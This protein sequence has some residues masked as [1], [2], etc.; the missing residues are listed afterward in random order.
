TR[1]GI[2]AALAYLRMASDPGALARSDVLDTVRRPSRKIARNVVEML[3]KRPATS[4]HD[5]RRLA[6]RLSGR[7]AERLE[8]YAADLEWVAD[9]LRT[10]GTAAAL[11]TVRTG[12][13]LG[14]AMDVLDGS[15]READRSTHADDLAALEAVAGL[16]REAATFEPWLREVLGRPGDPKG[17]QLSTIHRVKGRQWPYVVVY[18]VNDGLLPH[19]LASDEAE[20]RRIFHVGIT[21]ASA[22]V[23]V[24]SDPE[25]PSPF[26]DELTGS[27]ERRPIRARVTRPAAP[28]A[29]AAPAVDADPD[30]REALRAWRKEVA[31]RDGVPAYVVL[32]DNDLDGIAAA[33]PRSL[34]ELARCRGIGPAKLDRYGDELLAVIDTAAVKR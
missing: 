33:L 7:D 13:G 29:A 28:A 12:I 14:Q 17:V 19:R 6:S 15:R 21:R 20:E 30:V 11:R 2:R 4:V 23:V 3:T 26:L 32:K 24:L 1:T 10:G 22:Q 9:S 16:H 8:R 27:R 34:D 18:G 31:S 5:M 25:A